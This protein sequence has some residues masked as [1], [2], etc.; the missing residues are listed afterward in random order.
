MGGKEKL[1]DYF[2]GKTTIRKLRLKLS[3]IIFKT[4]RRDLS[5]T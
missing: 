4:S 2:Q 3:L 1:R 5:L